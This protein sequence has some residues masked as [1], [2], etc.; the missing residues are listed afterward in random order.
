[1]YIYEILNTKNKKRYIGQSQWKNNKRLN[2]HRSAL[3]RNRHTNDH[4]QSAWNKYGKEVFEFN[5]IAYAKSFVELDGLEASLVTQYKS[6]DRRYGYNVRKAGEVAVHQHADETKRL[7]GNSNRGNRHTKSQ[8]QK[9]AI[10]KRVNNYARYII[11]PSGK[12]YAV[13]SIRGFAK[14]HHLDRKAVMNVL[15]GRMRQTKGW[16]LSTTPKKLLDTGYASSIHQRKLTFLP[17]KSPDGSIHQV[18]VLGRFCREHDLMSGHIR[19]LFK[20]TRRSHKGWTLV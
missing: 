3:N 7:I 6:D 10:E 12:R 17:L 9:W 18:E 8:I 5:K 13:V 16:R 20:E 2:N 19:D 1:M 14:E 11:S 4:L 15:R